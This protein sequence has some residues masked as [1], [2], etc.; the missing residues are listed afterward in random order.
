MLSRFSH[1]Q[2]SVV[3]WTAA[4]QAP[5]S[6]RFSRQEYWSGLPF[7]SPEN[8]PNQGSNPFLCLL[9]WQAGSLPLVKVKSV[10]HVQL[11]VIPWTVAYQ[12]PLFVEFSRQEYWSGLLFPS[13]GCH[14]GTS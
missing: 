7:P 5:L 4:C 10:S 6:L 1:V 12:A 13:P 8:L 2:L 11:F 3:L 9:H 14:L